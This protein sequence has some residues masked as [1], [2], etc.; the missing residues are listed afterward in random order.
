MPVADYSEIQENITEQDAVD[1]EELQ[2]I[3][4]KSP[5]EL[6]SLMRRSRTWFAEQAEQLQ[7]LT[8]GYTAVSSGYLSPTSTASPGSMILFKYLPKTREKLPYW[9]MYPLVLPFGRFNQGFI[10]LNFHYVDYYSRLRL[11][12]VLT[13][14]ANSSELTKRTRLNVTWNTI[15]AVGKQSAHECVHKYLYSQIR[16]PIKSIHPRDWTTAL[17]LPWESFQ[18]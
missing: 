1:P 5:G 8:S 13:N 3:F 10:G 16:S 17:T 4:K 18:K 11:F 12:K 2:N 9:D 6:R 7:T 14:Y 15:E